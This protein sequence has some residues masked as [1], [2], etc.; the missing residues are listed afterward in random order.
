MRIF[1]AER[2]KDLRIGLQYLLLQEPD[3]E[4]IGAANNG[5]S[6]L[7]QVEASQPDVLLLD[8][9]LPGA[10]ITKLIADLQSLDFQLNI[11]VLS[12]RPE[13]KS[14]SMAAGAHYFMDKNS[15]PDMLMDILQYIRQDVT[16]G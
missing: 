13:D 8:W 3:Y 16:D 12:V 11:I 7:A 15:S 1:I 9:F 4:V 6:L 5:I 14:V 2:S 10:A